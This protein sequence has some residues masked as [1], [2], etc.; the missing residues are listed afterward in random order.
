[1]RVCILG[2]DGLEYKLV[3][4]LNLK[5][6]MQVEYGKVNVPIVGG[7][8]DPSTPI[9][10]T[11]FITGQPPEV[12]GVDMPEFWNNKMDGFRSYI[13]K[14]Q[15]IH[16]IAKKFKIGYQ[17]RRIIDADAK[18]PSRRNIKCDTL[19]DIIKPS[20][21]IGVPVFNKNINEIYPIGEVI[22]ARQDKEFR[23]EFEKRIRALFSQEVN[24]L[25]K[26]LKK[27]WKILMTHFHI[28]DLFG[29]AFWGTEKLVT[30]YEEMDNLAKK[31]KQEL[32][33]EDLLLIISDHGMSKL[34]HTKQGFYSINHKIGL[35]FP[36]ITDF[37]GIITSI[38]E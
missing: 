19:F 24:E 28:T 6:L 17:V 5:N 13:R 21:P 23:A 37:F 4:E 2:Y 1:M 32:S 33:S 31:V 11:S 8:N 29:H 30:L 9:V 12:H 22:K 27:D 15:T 26:E 36:E 14:H 35:S 25:F 7:I 38:L 18:F 16:K 3:N 20:S 34:G 10:W